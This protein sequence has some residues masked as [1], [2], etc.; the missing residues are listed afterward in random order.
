MQTLFLHVPMIWK[1]MQRSAW[2]DIVRWRLRQRN[3]YT[4]LQ[5]HA[6]MTTN[7]KKKKWDQMETCPQF[8]EKLF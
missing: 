1:V 7:L 6:L 2:K 4:K 3:N 5:C 8:A